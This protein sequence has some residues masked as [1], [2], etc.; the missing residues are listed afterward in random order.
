MKKNYYHIVFRKLP[1]L[2]AFLLFYTFSYSQKTEFGLAVGGMNYS[3]DLTRGYKI[4]D[5]KIGVQGL[6]RINFDKDVSFRLNLLYGQFSG[7]DSAHPIDPFAAIRDASFS[8]SVIEG[9]AIIEYHFLDY[10]NKHSTVK[11]S[12]Y[13]FAGI[14]I[15]KILNMDPALDN[16]SSLQPVIPFGGGVKHLIGKQFSASVEF[17][18]RKMFF[19]ELDR[20]SEGDVYDKSNTQFGNPNDN[21]WYHFLSISFSYIIFKI[22]CHYR[23]V[24]NKTIYN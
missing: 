22:P 15:T 10:K 2:S 21:D 17:G 9:S 12:P 19:D 1:I 3:G 13:F 7:S 18:A 14:G 4:L 6:Y 23:Y 5:Q 20:I 16:F 8:R 24:P 11:W